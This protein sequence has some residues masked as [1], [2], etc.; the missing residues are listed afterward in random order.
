MFF[1]LFSSPKFISFL[2][3]QAQ[4]WVPPVL[5]AINTH[6]NIQCYL[7]LSLKV[8]SRFSLHLSILFTSV[9][10]FVLPIYRTQAQ[11]RTLTHIQDRVLS[12]LYCPSVTTFHL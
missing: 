11:T 9:W 3:I 10:V 4:T 7:S 1:T 8:S 6:V 12:P 2:N 5:L